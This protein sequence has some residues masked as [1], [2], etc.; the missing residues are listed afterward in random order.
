MKVLQNWN[1]VGSAVNNL[2]RTGL[3]LHTD[4]AKCWDFNN[5][6]ELFLEKVQNRRAHIVDLGCGPSMHG[7]MTLELLRCMGYKNLIGIDF[8]VPLYTRLAAKMRG[9]LKH[10]SLKPYQMKRA[11][12]TCTGLND[13]M[14]DA[15]IL[16]SV[17]EHG[18]NLDK[19][20]LELYRIMKKGGIVYLSTDYW[21]DTLRGAP[22]S[23]ASG[24]FRNSNF[25]W[26]IFDRSS[27]KAIVGIA[28]KNGFQACDYGEIPSCTDRPVFWNSVYYT[29]IAVVFVKI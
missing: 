9:L 4:P 26:S 24:A 11:D 17:V 13:N 10:H 5:I 23:A 7:C 28:E 6:R 29:F 18:V 22:T 12:I 27:I 3:P 16:L 14:V 21:E 8:H 19:L 15:S 25:A 20:F 1:E 2:K